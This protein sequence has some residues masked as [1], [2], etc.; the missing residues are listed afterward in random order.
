MIEK[1][2]VD[3]SFDKISDSWQIDVSEEVAKP[4]CKV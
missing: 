2:K 4:I 1:K 3:I